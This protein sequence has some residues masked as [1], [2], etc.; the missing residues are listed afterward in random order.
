M[1]KQL[2]GALFNLNS[3]PDLNDAPK[4]EVCTTP[5]INS[6]VSAPTG[7]TMS[8][9]SADIERLENQ[10]GKLVDGVT[11]EITLQKLLPIVPRERRRI[12][13]YNGLVSELRK[14]GVTLNIKSRKTK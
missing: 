10:Y 12:E 3:R 13:A 1:I 14:H 4:G 7:S 5:Q 2:F 8:K 9:Y 6:S 11:I